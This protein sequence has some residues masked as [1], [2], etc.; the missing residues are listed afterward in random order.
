MGVIPEKIEKWILP[1]FLFVFEVIMLVLYGALVEY[2]SLGTP[3]PVN[4]SDVVAFHGGDP[5]AHVEKT[6][7]CMSISIDN[8]YISLLLTFAS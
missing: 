1:I 5:L 2:D 4:T 7:P 6:Y 8:T 3:A